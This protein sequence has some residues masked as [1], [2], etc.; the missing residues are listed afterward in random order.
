AVDTERSFQSSLARLLVHGRKDC[1]RYVAVAP[2][3]PAETDRLA[4]R[5]RADNP[6]TRNLGD[7][8]TAAGGISL[9]DEI[10]DRLPLK[11]KDC[12]AVQ[13]TPDAL[14]RKAALEAL[15]LNR[16]P[17]PW[18]CQCPAIAILLG[19]FLDQDEPPGPVVRG[20]EPED[21]MCRRARSCERIENE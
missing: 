12:V 5:V 20:I 17:H 21:S 7:P 1:A 4:A 19:A 16:R 18:R 15:C 3:V 13:T 11:I 2:A 8:L 9:D 6:R 14:E 10:G